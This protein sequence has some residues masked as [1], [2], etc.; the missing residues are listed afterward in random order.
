[1]SAP[2]AFMPD[3]AAG[4]YRDLMSRS[5]GTGND[6]AFA[7]M[8]ATWQ[9]GRASMPDWLGL[10]PVAFRKLVVHH[11]EGANQQW[12][13]PRGLS[14][15]SGLDSE[16][17]DLRRLL[18]AGAA[19]ASP[20]EGWMARVVAAGCMGADHLWQDLGLWSRGDLSTLLHRNFPALAARNVKDMKWKRFL[21]KELCE[22]EGIYTCRAPSCEACC[23][24]P[25]CF[26]PE[27]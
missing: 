3:P 15:D 5:A 13:Q 18:L 12:F 2:A 23:D 22:A 17:A 27:D 26:G 19:G 9:A 6:H 14:L 1:V 16:L 10:S 21:Y 7:C 24:Y 25:E 11:F 4:V 20:S 8:I